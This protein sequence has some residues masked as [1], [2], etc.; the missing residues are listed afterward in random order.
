MKSN[1]PVVP[2]VLRTSAYVFLLVALGGL[3]LYVGVVQRNLDLP[4]QPIEPALLVL[5]VVALVLGVV[6]VIGAGPEAFGRRYSAERRRRYNRSALVSLTV[7]VLFGVLWLQRDYGSPEELRRLLEALKPWL[8]L[9]AATGLL[10]SL[11]VLV[12]QR[13]LRGHRAQ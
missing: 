3:I 1:S 8:L 10:G 4:P 6:C 9:A 2:E 13:V 7:T 11:A 12:L 5:S